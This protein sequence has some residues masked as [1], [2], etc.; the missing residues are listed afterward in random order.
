MGWIIAGAV[1]AFIMILLMTSVRVRFEYSDDLRLKINWFFITFVSIPAK[2]KKQKRRNKKT[3]SDAETAAK[4]TAHAE[5]STDI[6]GRK[7]PDSSGSAPQ[8]SKSAGSASAGTSGKKKGQSTPQSQKLTLSDIWE[9]VKLVWDSLNTPLRRLL[10]ATRV[11]GFE[12]NIVCG[13]DDAAKAALNYGRTSAVAGA[14]EAFLEGCFTMK[15]PRYSVTV[16]FM[17]EETTTECVFT[18]RLTLIA[19]LA[20]LFWVVGRLVRNYLS[21][22]D[23][24]RAVDKLRK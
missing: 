2:T 24:A 23:A 11:S 5:E 4:D 16:D 14:V 19:A 9:L 20:F 21:R 10:K 12:L 22:K 15:K 1:I 6:S 18:A 7:A 17:S 13:G 8:N 3:E